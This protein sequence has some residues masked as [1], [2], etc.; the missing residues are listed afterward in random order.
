MYYILSLL[1]I[2]RHFLT[3]VFLHFIIGADT[4]NSRNGFGQKTLHTSYGDVEVKIPRD[5]QGEYEPKLIEK[6]KTML[7]EEI[8]RKIISMYAKGMTTG[9]MEAHIRDLYGVE[10]S[11][12]TIS[13]INRQDTAHSQGMAITAS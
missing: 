2:N 11:D 3:G 12:S 10:I 7:T 13:R 9:D 1:A 8:E 6:N 4:D 5:C